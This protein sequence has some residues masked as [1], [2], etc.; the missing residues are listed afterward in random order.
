MK[1]IT[2]FAIIGYGYMGHIYKKACIELYDR[3]NIENY[4]KYNLPEM[5]KDFKLKAIVDTIFTESTYNEEEGIWYF[6]SVDEMLN[7]PELEINS[8]V[9]ST[10]I[11]THFGIAKLL[12]LSKIS[13]L[14]EKPVCETAKEVKEINNFAK[15]NKIRIMPGHI[16]RY[17]PVTL[18][19]LE[20]VKFPAYGK[21]LKY[22][23]SRTSLKPE[24]VKEGILIDKLVHDLDLVHCIFGKYKIEDIKVKRS[25]NEI[26]ECTVYT[27]HSKGL[28]GEIVSSWLIEEKKREIEI[29]FEYGR[30]NGDLVNKKIDINRFMELSK[31][32]IAYNNNQ[33]KDQLVDFIAYSQNKSKTLVNMDDAV[34]A[35][36]L[37]DEVIKRTNSEI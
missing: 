10:P 23:F 37:I 17:N 29:D 31:H 24:R 36:L 7:R 32:I 16:E 18:E 30:F 19:A 26:M 33:I 3:K 27:R 8:A 6:P 5:L 2:S 28:R 20:T 34:K 1:K 12:I 35:A 21:P 11:K 15:K 25:D 9:I 22:K 4:Y 13:L 14:I